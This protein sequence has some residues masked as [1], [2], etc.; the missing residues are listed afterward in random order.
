MKKKKKIEIHSER[1][2]ISDDR[3]DRRKFATGPTHYLAK[4]VPELEKTLEAGDLNINRF[5]LLVFMFVLSI[6]VEGST[7]RATS[8]IKL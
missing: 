1:S 2:P 8:L 5:I 6:I 4:R 7:L 3:R